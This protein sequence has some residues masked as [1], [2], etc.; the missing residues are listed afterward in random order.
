MPPPRHFLPPQKA[1]RR[2]DRS[3]PIRSHRLLPCRHPPPPD[4]SVPRRWRSRL[5]FRFHSARP[6]L[7]FFR[8]STIVIHRPSGLT[9]ILLVSPTPE[10]VATVRT[11]SPLPS[12][13]TSTLIIASSPH[14]GWRVQTSARVS[15]D[16]I[17]GS[18]GSLL[19]G[20]DPRMTHGRLR[21]TC[22]R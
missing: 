16:M 9:K 19:D 1:E 3:H 2:R 13:V 14:P 18:I 21:E 22:S 20:T 6:R 4:N 10:P 8:N 12:G 7:R 17:R 5:R 15:S 11:Q